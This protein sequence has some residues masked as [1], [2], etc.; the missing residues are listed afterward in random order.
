MRRRSQM[1]KMTTG[2]FTDMADG[3][4]AEIDNLVSYAKNQASYD[5]ENRNSYIALGQDL[6]DIVGVLYEL[7]DKF[8]E[9]TT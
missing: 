9:S 1:Q 3:A 5:R 7:F 2:D 8:E 4:I 6:E